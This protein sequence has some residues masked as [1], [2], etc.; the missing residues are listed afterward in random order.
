MDRVGPLLAKRAPLSKPW[1]AALGRWLR[2]YRE[3]LTSWEGMATLV[4]TGILVTSWGAF[5]AGFGGLERTLALGAAVLAGLPIWWSTLRGLWARDFTV[6]VLVS[7]A[8]IAALLV[9]Q[10]Q[11][12]AIVAVMLLGGGL[13]TLNF[14]VLRRIVDSGAKASTKRQGL[15]TAL[16]FVKF[17]ALIGIV[18]VAVVHA[19]IN[20]VAFL[21]GISVAFAALI[22]E[23]L[24]TLIRQSA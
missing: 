23:S 9:G 24:R 1:L 15:L 8:I 12:G 19:P 6:D 14:Y 18:Y 20:M 22:F 4:A 7:T 3:P 13:A 17:A 10:Y 2:T 21:I 5:L 16:F 11:A